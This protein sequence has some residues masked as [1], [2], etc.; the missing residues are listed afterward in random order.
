MASRKIGRRMVTV[1]AAFG[2]A[3]SAT[4]TV[5]SQSASALACGGTAAKTPWKS[6]TT[7]WGE[8]YAGSCSGDYRV[9][10]ERSR[11]YGWET[12]AA[13]IWIRAN[14]GTVVTYNCAGTGTHTY[15]TTVWQSGT[16]TI[17]TS[18]TFRTSC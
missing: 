12:V 15:R 8:G 14:E 11:Y 6:G 10:L 1:A 4:L 16:G 18:G 5:G 7:I 13:S 17:K 3:L 9:M 2:L